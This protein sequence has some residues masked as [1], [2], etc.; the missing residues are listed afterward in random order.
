MS[1][2]AL[3]A[4]APQG[5]SVKHRD[6]VADDGGLAHHDARPVVDEHALPELSAGV[7]V[8]LELLVDLKKRTY[9]GKE[10]EG[11]TGWLP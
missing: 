7:D 8:Y 3:H 6:I 4:G 1:V 9:M 11:V 10:G 5:D 2:S